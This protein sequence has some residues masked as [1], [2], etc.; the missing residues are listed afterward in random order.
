VTYNKS[1]VGHKR[2]AILSFVLLFLISLTAHA[3]VEVESPK[4]E[5]PFAG[6]TWHVTASPYLWFS[7]L[8]G[9]LNLLGHTAAVHQSFGDIF[10]NLKFGFM[11]LSEVRRGRVGLLTDVL[12]VRVGDQQAIPAP[13]LPFPVQ[14]KLST[15][16]FTL[17]PEVAY[18]V[19]AQKH[20]SA[21]VLGGFR[22]YHL[23]A[24][25]NFNAGP[26]GQASYSGTNDWADV[27]A[28]ARFLVK[29]TPKIGA[30]LIGDAGGGGASPT[31]EIA[32]GAGYK[33]LKR[34]TVQIGYKRLYF[35]RQD[36]NN[37]GVE[38]TQQG[39]VLGTTIRFR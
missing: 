11:G 17:T 33:V 36:G 1:L 26:L 19:Y 13:Q 15:S 28:G 3:Q 29:L 18:R 34:S 9:N 10:S 8:D 7:G 21:D 37:F 38:S 5:P 35:N 2:T 32:Y 22:Y 27:T 20:L 12:F 31:W 6:D 24:S 23:G 14:V 25:S 16:T 4:P 30:Y 39:L